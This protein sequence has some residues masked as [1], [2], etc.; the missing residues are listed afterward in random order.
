MR[1]IIPIFIF[2]L[3][4]FI[5]QAEDGHSLWLRANN[6]APVEVICPKKTVILHIA[7]QELRQGWQGKAN[8]KI[9]LI[10]KNDNSLK[11]DGFRLSKNGIQANTDRGILYGVYEMLRRQQTGRPIDE[12][13]CNPSYQRRILNHWDNLDGTI[14]RGYAGHSIF[15]RKGADAFVVTETDK[16]LWQEYARAN[17]SIGINGTVLNNVNASPSILTADYLQR[18]KAI[19]DVLRPYGITAYLSIN[20]ASPQVIGELNTADP[21][22]PDAVGICLMI[23]RWCPVFS[24]TLRCPPW[25]GTIMVIGCKNMV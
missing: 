10:V 1:E 7:E 8:E 14:E 15:W 12:E 4:P 5:L 24:Y 3:L 16:R 17:A 19:A 23:V 13:V 21:L 18:T 11:N 6:T 20:F 22:K 9:T 2:I 25:S